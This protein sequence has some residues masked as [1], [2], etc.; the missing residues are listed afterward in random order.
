M[1]SD[2]LYLLLECGLAVQLA[3][4][5]G[6]VAR[7]DFIAGLFFGILATMA[8]QGIACVLFAYL[9]IALWFG[10]LGWT[11][12][13]GNLLALVVVLRLHA[14]IGK[15][16]PT[17]FGKQNL[18]SL[19]ALCLGFAAAM[20][21]GIHFFTPDLIPSSMTGDPERHF[22]GLVDLHQPSPAM[23][24]K[25]IYHLWA[26]FLA[27]APLPLAK[28]QLFVAFA[29]FSLGLVTSSALL[30]ALRIVEDIR[31]LILA[32]GALLITFG[33]PYF[34]VQYG[35]FTL[36]LSAVFLF[37]AL[38]LLLRYRETRHPLAYALFTLLMTGLALTHAYLAP[39]AVLMMI[40]F[41]L[42]LSRPAGTSVWR[43]TTQHA[44]YWAFFVLMTVVSNWS[45]ATSPE[46][47]QQILP[48]RG[49]VNGDF[50]S[51]LLPFML[52]SVPFLV[53][54]DPQRN[55]QALLLF[56]ACAFL[57]SLT[58]YGFLLQDIAAP[59]Y[60]NRNQLVLLPLLTIGVLGSLQHVA[61]KSWGWTKLLVA[62]LL[63]QVIFPFAYY[64]RRNPP[65]AL[66]GMN[67]FDL[68]E[69]N[70]DYIYFV[71]AQ[72]ASYSPLQMTARD[73]VLMRK[74]V[75]TCLQE[76]PQRMAVL[77]SDHEVIWFGIYTGIE[78]T[79]VERRDGFIDTAGYRAT[80]EAWRLQ[81]AGEPI[82]IIKHLNHAVPRP[83][84]L[85][86]R[87]HAA[88]A[89]EGDSFAIYRKTAEPDK[90]SRS[91]L[92]RPAGGR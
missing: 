65:L 12:A 4:L 58:M 29:I 37:A 76:K 2:L 35:Y 87:Q 88:L 40:G 36:L 13:I 60:V 90:H 50:V 34:S 49:F 86:V 84:L 55:N 81:P 77:G 38:T 21:A 39:E 30:L 68:L 85:W 8:L 31:A 47:L 63:L 18:R 32:L 46:Q 62:A 14:D 22:L 80:Y 27:N 43:Q 6:N 52:F 75:S 91:S 64:S 57:F 66:S 61:V 59:Y 69:Q 42:W 82:A 24:S 72:T 83:I 11:L 9:G 23:E 48:A 33:Y 10:S 1:S 78:P 73:R 44:P 19:L 89:C 51:N 71:T 7:L 53:R 3:L 5:I 54:N 20:V 56:I 45:I 15:S 79:L 17:I 28:D 74:I 67:F 25:P 26:G 92:E 70:S 41:T 16:A